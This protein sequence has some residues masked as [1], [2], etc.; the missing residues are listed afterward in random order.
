MNNQL[1]KFV[2]LPGKFC[3]DISFYDHFYNFIC[4]GG[5]NLALFSSTVPGTNVASMTPVHCVLPW[6]TNLANNGGTSVISLP[7]TSQLML[8]DNNNIKS[9]HSVP[10][11]S[12]IFLYLAQ[13]TTGS[14]YISASILTQMLAISN[15]FLIDQLI[16]LRCVSDMV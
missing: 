11:G 12:W 3:N 16:V 13:Y 1:A 7:G 2:K 8:T 6:T 10:V 15:Q 5:V 9:A 4:V 14:V